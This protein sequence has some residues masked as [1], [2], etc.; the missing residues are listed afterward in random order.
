VEITQSEQKRKKSIF[1]GPLGITSSILTFTFRDP[2]RI[3]EREGADNI[4]DEIM[5]ENFAN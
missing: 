1:L 3:R 5:A 2:T 4:F